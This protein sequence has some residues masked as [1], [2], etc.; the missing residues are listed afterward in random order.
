MQLCFN[1]KKKRKVSWINWR[2]AHSG[3]SSHGENTRA[4]HAASRKKS[5]NNNDVILFS[6]LASSIVKVVILLAV[7]RLFTSFQNS[8]LLE[9]FSTNF[10]F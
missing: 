9:T 10:C 1:L 5:V 6:P 2:A 7:L 8:V 3:F 4:A